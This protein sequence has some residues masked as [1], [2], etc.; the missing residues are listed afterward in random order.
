MK[1]AAFALFIL[2]GLALLAG[3]VH[4]FVALQTRIGNGEVPVVRFLAA[5][6]RGVIFG[7]WGMVLLGVIVALP[8][9]WSDF[10][11]FAPRVGPSQG[12]LVLD[13]GMP[14]SEVQRRS[15]LK[16]V[17]GFRVESG[18]YRQLIAEV[19][20][21][22]EVGGT[23]FPQ[24]RYYWMQTYEHDDPR[25]EHISVGISPRK[26]PLAEL[27]E[28]ERL[29]RERLKADGWTPGHYVYRTPEQLTLHGG[30]R[31]GGDG[32]YWGK[33]DTLLILSVNR[34][35]EEKRGEP[36]GAGEFILYVDI[37]ARDVSRYAD[38]EFEP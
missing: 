18:G 16:L 12:V 30:A 32:R 34:M 7:M 38:L 13:V 11:G 26:L 28:A 31:T 35:D 8:A 9:M 36:A 33:G 23:R 20:F 24:C 37:V 10:F 25:L 5:H 15:T 19:V 17:P 6:E 21:D 3:M 27:K 29:V 14:L 22:L 1:L 2:L 4:V